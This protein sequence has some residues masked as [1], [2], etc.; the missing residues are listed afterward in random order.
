MNAARWDTDL[1]IAEVPFGQ[2]AVAAFEPVFDPDP[3]SIDL[4]FLGEVGGIRLPTR[5]PLRSRMVYADQF[6]LQPVA[7]RLEA[8]L[9]D[10]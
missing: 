3:M 1:S 2:V 4:G 6:P 5:T 7:G 8:R 9:R 10:E